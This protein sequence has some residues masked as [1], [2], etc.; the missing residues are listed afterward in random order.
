MSNANREQHREHVRAYR[1]RR[2]D[3][4]ERL[5]AA[6]TASGCAR[7]KGRFAAVAMVLVLDGRAVGGRS[8]QRAL[9]E[10]AAE[11]ARARPYCRCCAALQGG[12]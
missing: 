1:V 11:I 9:E 3:E 8:D 4:I 5:V 6:R 7:C 10:V 2:A 12:T